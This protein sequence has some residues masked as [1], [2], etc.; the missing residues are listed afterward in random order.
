MRRRPRTRPPPRRTRRPCGRRSNPTGRG[1]RRPRRPPLPTATVLAATATR[2]P[3]CPSTM[4]RPRRPFA[5]TSSASPRTSS[6]WPTRPTGRTWSTARRSSTTLP[7]PPTRCAPTPSRP[8]TRTRRRMG[9]PRPLRASAPNST[10]PS[11]PTSAPSTP[12]RLAPRGS[13]RPT[14]FGWRCG[15][16]PRGR[17]GCPSACRRRSRRR[18][19][20]LGRRWRA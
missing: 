16:S 9:R 18:K 11:W 14:A 20:R 7:P 13:G 3:S 6:T 8:L 2:P 12:S 19:R 15:P 10:T 17:R 4:G 5:S 1:W